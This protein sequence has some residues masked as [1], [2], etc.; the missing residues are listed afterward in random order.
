VAY[1]RSGT[2]QSPWDGQ[3]PTPQR[4][5]Q[6]LKTLLESLKVPSPFILVGH[7]WGGALARY[8]AG[9]YPQMVKAIL[10][11]DPTDVTM[12]EPMWQQMFVSFGAT[13]KDLE[14][15]FAVMDSST[16]S[17][18]DAIRA[19]ALM[20]MELLRSRTLE[21]RHL[22][23]APRIPS[24]VLLASRVA[25]LPKGMLPFDGDAYARA[26]QNARVNGLRA[27]T[28]GSGR[29]LVVDG[30]GHFVHRDAPDVVIKEIQR[31]IDGTRAQ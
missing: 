30:T 19:E 15:F 20:M 7:S 4:A 16:R 18:P 12:T 17:Q 13:A 22:K 8:F 28:Q 24:S 14:A 27:W 31:L 6:R 29:Y 9:E 25:P 26:L 23:P 1:D 2:G 10:Y 11:I 3:S 5:N 21:E